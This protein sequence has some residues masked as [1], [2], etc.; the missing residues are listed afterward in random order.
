M[1]ATLI[2]CNLDVL[3]GLEAVELIEQLEHRPLHL[4]VATR[5]AL[6]TR[7]ADRVDLV[8]KDDRRCVLPTTPHASIVHWVCTV[9]ELKRNAT[10]IL[11]FTKI[12]S[13]Q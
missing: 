2:S 11:Q 7:R 12:P 6:E 1:I 8:H 10:R 9:D 3:L 4:A 5:A 13:E